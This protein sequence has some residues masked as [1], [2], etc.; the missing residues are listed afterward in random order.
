MEAH[1]TRLEKVFAVRHR[2]RHL[3]G[4][5]CL[6]LTLALSQGV[7]FCVGCDGHASLHA[8][9]HS[10]D[11]AETLLATPSASPR[12]AD[13]HRDDHSHCSRCVDIP[14]SMNLVENRVA[15][16][17]ADL[18]TSFDLALF[19]RA[20]TSAGQSNLYWAEVMGTPSYFIPLDS[21]VLVI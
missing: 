14:L 3:I 20:L 10:H 21:V 8:S 15:F 11:H 1:A 4:L 7:S 6:G 9:L 16:D 18:L 2:K 19:E 12:A 13:G 5:L 17:L